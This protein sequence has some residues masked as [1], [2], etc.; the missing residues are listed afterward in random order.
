VDALLV[1]IAAGAVVVRSGCGIA[2]GAVMEARPASLRVVPN[3]GRART[4]HPSSVLTSA[5]TEWRAGLMPWLTQVSPKR[6][7]GPVDLRRRR[8]RGHPG[9]M[10]TCQYIHVTVEVVAVDTAS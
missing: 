10:A 5:W 1:E 4:R 3:V 2:A 6:S 8:P 7:S 9:D